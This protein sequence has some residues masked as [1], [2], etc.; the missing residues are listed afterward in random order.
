[1]EHSGAETP[2]VAHKVFRFEDPQG[3]PPECL[4]VS[5]PEVSLSPSASVTLQLLL[6]TPEWEQMSCFRADIQLIC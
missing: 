6:H 5:I 3:S 2:S 4:T 1:M